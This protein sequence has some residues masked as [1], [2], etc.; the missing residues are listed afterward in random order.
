[1]KEKIN[2]HVQIFS[3]FPI[4]QSILVLTLFAYHLL[5]LLLIIFY[6]GLDQI[7]TIRTRT[8]TSTRLSTTAAYF[9]PKFTCSLLKPPPLSP[10]SELLLYIGTMVICYW[11]DDPSILGINT[12]KFISASSLK[13]NL[14]LIIIKY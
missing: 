6:Y 1:M 8:R 13:I 11:I 12:F 9:E 5:Y 3:P 4:L 14:N 2:E 10:H 7:E